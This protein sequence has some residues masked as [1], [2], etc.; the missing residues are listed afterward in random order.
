MFWD[1]DDLTLTK[2]MPMPPTVTN[3]GWGLTKNG[4]HLIASDGSEYL[5]W[6]DP[7]TLREVER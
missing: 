2:Q 5:Y 6:W 4:T 1:L 7:V 3:E